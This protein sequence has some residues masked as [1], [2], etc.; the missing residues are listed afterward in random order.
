MVRHYSKPVCIGQKQR[1]YLVRMLCDE[2]RLDFETTE[3]PEF[4]GWQWVNY[5]MPAKDVVYFKRNVYKRA[6]TELLPLH[7]KFKKLATENS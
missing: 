6:L 7:V 4:D 3:K 5:W 1:W 2:S